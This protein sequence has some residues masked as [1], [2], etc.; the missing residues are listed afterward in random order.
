ML[1]TM[2]KINAKA[3][4]FSRSK[5]VVEILS[6]LNVPKLCLNNIIRVRISLGY[7]SIVA[8]YILISTID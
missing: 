3:A 1:T 4:I 2:R 6:K 8:V 5:Q 7:L